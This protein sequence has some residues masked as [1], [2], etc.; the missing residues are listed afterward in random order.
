[1]RLAPLAGGG[2]S[3]KRRLKCPAVREEER[4]CLGLSK[5][6]REEER[7]PVEFGSRI[8]WR[9]LPGEEDPANGAWECPAVREEERDCLGLSKGFREEERTLSNSET[10][11]ERAAC[12]VGDVAAADAKI[13]E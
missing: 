8:S 7:T 11:L 5:G 12:D 4:D 2:G 10:Q 1:K 6:F 3:G 9:R 13:V